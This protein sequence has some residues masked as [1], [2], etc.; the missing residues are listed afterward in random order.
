VPNFGSKMGIDATKKW[1]SEGFDREWP[2][3]ITMS[4]EVVAKVDKL[5]RELG[6]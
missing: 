5:W 2:P 1:K 6:L 4:P 3:D